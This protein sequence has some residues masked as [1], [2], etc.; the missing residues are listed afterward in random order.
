M[1]TTRKYLGRPLVAA[2]PWAIRSIL[3][4]QGARDLRAFGI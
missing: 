1:K 3:V 4:Q 2:L